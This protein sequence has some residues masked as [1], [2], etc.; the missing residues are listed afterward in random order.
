LL[1]LV[2]FVQFKFDMPLFT[3]LTEETICNAIDAANK[4]VVLAAPGIGGVV[5]QSLAGAHRRLGADAVQVVL[6]IG[7]S[8]LN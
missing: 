6:D 8:N 5:A 3:T 4:H 1:S 2:V 7:I